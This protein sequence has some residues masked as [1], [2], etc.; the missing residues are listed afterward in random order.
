MIA[1]G[2]YPSGV[3]QKGR[4]ANAWPISGLQISTCHHHIHHTPC[5]YARAC[6]FDQAIGRRVTICRANALPFSS[7]CTSHT[8]VCGDK[9]TGSPGEGV[10][11]C[12]IIP[13]DRKFFVYFQSHQNTVVEMVCWL[14][15][16]VGVY[17]VC[18]AFSYSACTHS[19]RVH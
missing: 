12:L 16:S 3:A 2:R 9:L 19:R 7:R 1:I 6:P 5:L 13:N 18:A 17:D 11:R 4:D 8:P 14:V 15:Y 10:S